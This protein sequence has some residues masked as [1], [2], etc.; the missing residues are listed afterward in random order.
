MVSADLESA[1]RRIG[2]EVGYIK[3]FFQGALF[4]SLG[5][6]T[7]H[8]LAT[9]AQLGLARGFPRP[10][11]APDNPPP[12][13]VV[14]DP[15][16]VVA[17]LPASQRFFA[18][19]GTT[20]RGFQLDRLAV[21]EILNSDG[22]S[23]GGNAVVVLNAE[24]RS[25]VATLF[26]RSLAVVGFLDSGNVFARVADLDLGRLRGTAGFGMRYDSPLGPLR[27]DFGFKMTRLTFASGR[28]RGWELH[29]SIGEA[30]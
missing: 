26:G 3:T 24:L 11:G 15:D 8:V 25:R 7:R 17:D 20:V 13:P 28:E 30:F 27:L 22:L 10:I 12:P 5:G 23:N 16:T 6:N 2:S 14:L 21:P 4:T 1:M 29:L 18:G 19:G 9:R